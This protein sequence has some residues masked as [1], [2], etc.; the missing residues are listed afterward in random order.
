MQLWILFDGD[1]LALSYLA[2]DLVLAITFYQLSR[3]R[4]FPAPLF[5]LHAA[6]VMF[7]AY[8]VAIDQG[9]IWMIAVLNRTFDL[10]LA[11]II[12]CSVYRMRQ[13]GD[14]SAPSIREH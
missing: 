7:N 14:K 2:L 12:F 13:Y 6:N 11:Y 3:G 4:W 9:P 10:T 1:Y 8:I 5:F